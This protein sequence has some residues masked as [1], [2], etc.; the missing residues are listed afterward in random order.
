MKKKTIVIIA[1]A[2][3]AFLLLLLAPWITNATQSAVVE[4]L[5]E[6][7]ARY[8]YLGEGMALKDIPK[9]VSLFPFGRFVAFPGEAG[10]IVAF[11]ETVIF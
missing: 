5:G 11:Y 6:T 9:Q 7:E 2:S 10:W 8:I 4:K 3:S 1:M